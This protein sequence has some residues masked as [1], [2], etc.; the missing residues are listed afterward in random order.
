MTIALAAAGTGGHVMPALA[1][2][3]RLAD[4]DLVFVGGDRFEADAVPA[5]GYELVQVELRGLQRRLT[6]ENLSIPLVV[7][8]AAADLAELFEARD[9]RVLLATG[10]YV[11]VPAAMAARRLD[12][13]YFLQ[14]QN[15]H[16]GLA[17]RLMGRRAEATF[18]SFPDTHDAV[19]PRFVGNPV[20]AAIADL[21]VAS[22]RP[23]AR[24]RYG[25]DPDRVTVGVV[26]GSLGSRPV[27][28]AVARALAAW[29]GPPVQVVHLAGRR[30]EGE[31]ARAVADL[32]L[33]YRV[34]GFEDR[35]EDFFAA[36]DLAVSRASGMVAELAVTGTPAIVIPGDFGSKGH[37]AAS[38]RAFERAG[39]VFV[40]A[41]ET[42]GHELGTAL[43]TL[44][45]DADRRATMSDAARSIGR[46][47][48]ATEI[49]EELIRAAA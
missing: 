37:Q 40:V 14:E 23:I 22:H 31:V 17:N 10:G 9:V 2:A 21:D 4:Q 24:E 39:A 46:P 3:E 7:R 18:T 45:A 35:M 34:V 28:E 25:L 13:P 36:I 49:A 41:E 38:A 32:D 47:G 15:A 16:A 11:T 19:K 12:I 33:T 5:A 20:R 43:R 26:G 27:N 1:V 6:L 8:R 30:F 42:I 48:A 29:D 44:C